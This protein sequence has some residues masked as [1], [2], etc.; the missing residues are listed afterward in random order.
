MPKFVFLGTDLV[1]YAMALLL[2]W[3]VWRVASNA[4]LRATWEKVVRDP[5]ALSAAIVLAVFALVTLVDSVHFRRALPAAAGAAPGAAI[6]YAPTT[7]SLL[8]VVLARQVA[9]RE[10]GYSP[11]LAY[12]AFEKAPM[13]VDGRPLR[14]FPRLVFGGAQ[15]AE[16]DSQ[17]AGDVLGRACFG[18]LA[19]VVVAALVVALTAFFVRRA[20]DGTMAALRDI[21]ADK[22]HLP[23]RAALLTFAVICVLDR[24]SVV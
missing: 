16:P 20:H 4:N 17:W 6:S 19:G 18:L 13:V 11:P 12:K 23:L 7:Q 10:T 3:Y 15:L 14:A 1:L 5:A 21:A 2:A 8:D 22:T 24:K 9:S